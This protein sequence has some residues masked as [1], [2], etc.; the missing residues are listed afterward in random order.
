MP[1]ACTACTFPMNFQVIL[2]LKK[3]LNLLIFQCLKSRRPRPCSCVGRKASRA[4]STITQAPYGTVSYSTSRDDLH[5]TF[6]K[7]CLLARVGAFMN[8][9]SRAHEALAQPTCATIVGC[10]GAHCFIKMLSGQLRAAWPRCIVEGLVCMTR[11]THAVF[12][13]FPCFPC[14][15]W[16]PVSRFLWAVEERKFAW[17]ADG[18]VGAE[19]RLWHAE[20]R[21]EWCDK[22]CAPGGRRSACCFG[23]VEAGEECLF[24]SVPEAKAAAKCSQHEWAETLDTLLC[25][26]SFFRYDLRSCCSDTVQ[27]WKCLTPSM[28]LM[29]GLSAVNSCTAWWH[30]IDRFGSLKPFNLKLK[31]NLI[32]LWKPCHCTLIPPHWQNGNLLSNPLLDLSKVGNKYLFPFFWV[33]L[34]L[35]AFCWGSLMASDV[36]PRQTDPWLPHDEAAD[37]RL[38]PSFSRC[39]RCSRRKKRTRACQMPLP[40]YPGFEKMSFDWIE[41]WRDHDWLVVTGTWLDYLAIPW[42]CHHPIWLTHI[43]QRGWN[44]Q[45][46]EESWIEDSCDNMKWNDMTWHW[47]DMTWHECGGWTDSCE[48]NSCLSL[49]IFPS[50]LDGHTFSRFQRKSNRFRS[51]E[52]RKGSLGVHFQEAPWP[53]TVGYSLNDSGVSFQASGKVLYWIQNQEFWKTGFKTRSSHMFSYGSKTGFHTPPYGGTFWWFGPSQRDGRPAWRQ[54][55]NMKTSATAATLTLKF[56][57]LKSQRAWMQNSWS[58]SMRVLECLGNEEQ[59]YIL[60]YPL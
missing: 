6:S 17:A 18:T 52:I 33:F 44:H 21:C 55:I 43:F 37:S 9:Y 1:V 27:M 31:A 53:S 49:I 3:N 11:A 58:K 38:H 26:K 10:S 19:V 59:F 16:G 2:N 30:E 54:F 36:S 34:H 25:L 32:C 12:I 42:E 5:L 39:S 51:C 60:A 15:L 56:S 22:L 40:G 45:P 57:S 50:G 13:R 28:S 8:E 14:F 47:H 35:S 46:D 48:R 29:F 7:V 23:C 41:S 20:L 24:L 4:P